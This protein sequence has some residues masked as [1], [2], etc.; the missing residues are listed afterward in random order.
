MRA[1]FEPGTRRRW[2]SRFAACRSSTTR[3]PQELVVNN[4]RAPA[5]LRDGKQR[6]IVYADRTALEVFASDGLTY[7]PMPV[8]PKA[9]ERS[10]AVGGKGGPVRFGRLDVYELKSIWPK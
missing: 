5:P 3:R 8:I 10:V 9:E 4:H 1:E 7:V 6:L 2:R